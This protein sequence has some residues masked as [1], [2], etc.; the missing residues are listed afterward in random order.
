MSIQVDIVTPEAL[1][2][3][4]P[5]NAIYAPGW[6]GEFGAMPEH[7]RYLALLRAGRLSLHTPDGEVMYVVGRGF[8]EI[9]PDKVTILADSCE[10]AENTDKEKAARDLETAQGELNALNQYSPESEP[11]MAMAELAQARLDA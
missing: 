11:A 4:G 7:E 3:S 2:F 9:G 6:E 10:L 5:A 1:F 8:A